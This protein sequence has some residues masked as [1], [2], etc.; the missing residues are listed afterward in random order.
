[1]NKRI[2]IFITIILLS[3]IIIPIAY[4]WRWCCSHHW[5]QAYCWSNW[6]WICRDGTQSP[7]CFCWG[8]G[9]WFYITSNSY[10][11]TQCKN[12]YIRVNWKWCITLDES[13]RQ[14]YWIHSKSTSATTCWCEKW[15]LIEEKWGPC[16]SLDEV[17]K[18][19]IWEHAIWVWDRNCWC[20][21]WRTY[22]PTKIKCVTLDQWCEEQFW[23]WFISW[24][25]KNSC[26]CKEWLYNIWWKC[27]NLDN[28]CESIYWENSIIKNWYCDCKN[29]YILYNW[30]CEKKEI[31]KKVIINNYYKK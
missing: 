21:N 4:A 23:E 13:C 28:Y 14:Q 5:W 24:K 3:N 1:M 20:E 8:W 27:V 6:K 15:F 2:S 16:I 22:S 29:G 12:W 11:K 9:W 25:T 7:S 17:C 18:H 31:I 30:K 10:T 19:E 26:I